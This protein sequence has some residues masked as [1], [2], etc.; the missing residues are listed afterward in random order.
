LF[1]IYMKPAPIITVVCATLIAIGTA[2][3]L[4]AGEV[5]KKPYPKATPP[6][7]PSPI[8]TP[9]KERA[10]TAEEIE[11]D[12]REHNAQLALAIERALVASNPQQRETAFTFLV[13]V[14]VQLEPQRLVTMVAAQEP[15]ERRDVLRNEVARQWITRD[16]DAAIKWLKSL[17]SEAERRESV[18]VAVKTLAAV[19]PDQAVYVADQFGVGRDDGSLEH[20]VQIWAEHNLDAATRWIE[21]QPAGPATDQLRNRIE[22]VRKTRQSRG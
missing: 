7:P 19:A 2:Y 16:R 12:A 13:P 20:I 22:R 10:P 17:D 6:P 5:K 14:L 9:S 1:V 8:Y 3:W 21:T 4:D 18:Q 11:R 15:G